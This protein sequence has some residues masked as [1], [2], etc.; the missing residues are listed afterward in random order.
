[1]NGTLVTEKPV[2]CTTL[3]EP[4]GRQFMTLVFPKS[5][6][7]TAPTDPYTFTVPG[8]EGASVEIVVP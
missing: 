4:D 6:A 5:S 8:V 7:A 1:M 3:V 2:T